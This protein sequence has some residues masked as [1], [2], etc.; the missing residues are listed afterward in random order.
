LVK[1]AAAYVPAVLTVI[2]SAHLAHG[3]GWSAHLVGWAV[4]GWCAFVGMFG[5]LME[6]PAVLAGIS[7]LEHVAAMPLEAFDGPAA[8]WLTA[9]GLGM[10]VAAHALLRRRDLR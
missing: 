3:L 4:V 9:I 5:Q 10:L 7:P 2:A 1:A 8:A 6:L